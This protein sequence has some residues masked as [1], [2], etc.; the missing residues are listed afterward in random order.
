MYTLTTQFLTLYTHGLYSIALAHKTLKV[1]LQYVLRL[2][3]AMMPISS[4]AHLKD[5]KLLAY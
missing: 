2:N 4:F 3:L 1:L 5:Y